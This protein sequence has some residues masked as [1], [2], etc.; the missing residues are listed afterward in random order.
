MNGLSYLNFSIKVK[1]LPLTPKGELEKLVL[2]YN[3]NLL[4]NLRLK[5]PL[6]VWGQF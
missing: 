1:Y 6:G 3:L 5:A 2:I 4:E